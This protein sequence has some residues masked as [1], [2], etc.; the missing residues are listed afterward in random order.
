MRPRRCT[1]PRTAGGRRKEME[2]IPT[3]NRR[4]KSQGEESRSLESLSA[5]ESLQGGS[6]LLKLGVWLD[7]RIYGE[8]KD[9][10][11]STRWLLKEYKPTSYWKV[12]RPPIVQHQIPVIWRFW[13][14][15][16]MRLKR[17]NGLLRCW[18]ATSDLLSWWPSQML[19]LAMLRISHYLWRSKA[20]T[21]SWMARYCVS[22]SRSGGPLLT[23]VTEMVEQRRRRPTMQNLYSHGQKRY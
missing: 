21:T 8:V 14:N 1:L 4:T 9:S 19:H 5:K 15:T 13:R 20:M 2:H 23:Y 10:F 16:A 18:K 17:S 22:A 7:G 3:H 12:F 11:W 6:R